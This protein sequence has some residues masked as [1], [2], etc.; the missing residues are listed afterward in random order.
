MMNLTL[1]QENRIYDIMQIPKDK[2]SGLVVMSKVEW[3]ARQELLDEKEWDNWTAQ[4][5]TNFLCSTQA[6]QD[7]L[8]NGIETPILDCLDLDWKNELAK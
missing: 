4:Q 2:R 6:N 8:N 3:L 5:E 7:R 1:E